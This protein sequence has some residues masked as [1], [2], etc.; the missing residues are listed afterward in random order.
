MLVNALGRPL[1]FIVTAGQVGDI[2]QAP[3]LLRGQSGDAAL[4]D[5]ACDSMLKSAARD[6]S[7][8]R[9]PVR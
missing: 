8:R 4:A 1:R 6:L 9:T 5:K 3:V 7:R 2:T